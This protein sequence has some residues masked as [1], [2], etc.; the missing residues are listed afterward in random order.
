MQ[1][2][3]EKPPDVRVIAIAAM[4]QN[5]AIGAGNALPWNLPEDLKFF[6]ESTRG[7]TLLMGRKTYASIGRPLPGR[8]T[9]VLSRSVTPISGVEVINELGAITRLMPAGGELWI[10]G[11]A[12][13]Y[14]LTLPWW[15]EVL[16]T[17][18]KRTV[19]GDAFFPKFEH[20]MILS[21]VVREA[22]DFTI[23]RHVVVG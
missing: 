12:E 18:V 4:A 5:R 6:R 19:E 11:G 3:P 9:L 1:P 16:I 7:K 10:C 2:L 23:E 8:R 14:T 20:L 21:E 15:D 17:R 13:I 22:R